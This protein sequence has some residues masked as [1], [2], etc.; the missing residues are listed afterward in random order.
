MTSAHS[1]SLTSEE[2]EHMM[3]NIDVGE[4]LLHDGYGDL[5]CALSLYTLAVIDASRLALDKPGEFYEGMAEGLARVALGI[6][7]LLTAYESGNYRDKG[8]D[9][10]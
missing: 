6:T 3:V 8:D 5:G 9:E 10:S 1:D 2:I 7:G 4:Q